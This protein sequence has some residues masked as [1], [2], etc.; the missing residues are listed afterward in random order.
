MKQQ[1]IV[2]LLLTA[3]ASGCRQTRAADDTL[4]AV[5][6]DYVLLSLTIGEKEEGYIDSYYGPAE[7]QA[8]AKADAPA[9]DLNT[10]ANRT[11]ALRERVQK[12]AENAHGMDQR[13][14]KFLVAKLTAASTR[15]RM[16]K[17]EKLS[18]ADEAEG[19]FAVRPTLKPLSSYEPILKQIGAMISG[20][21]PLDQRVAAYEARFAIPAE[22]QKLVFQAAIGECKARTARHLALPRGENFELGF[23]TG[24]SWSAYNYYKGHYRSRIDINTDLPSPFGAQSSRM[25]RRLPRS[26]RLECLAGTAPDE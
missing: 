24:K 8:K 15:L 26:S 10:L 20:E 19:L 1:L 7:L 4:D 3:A 23:V 14:A 6:R 22:R 16:L 13:R 2:A 25:P 11:S 12:L 21:G 5:A 17:G 9:E 18:F